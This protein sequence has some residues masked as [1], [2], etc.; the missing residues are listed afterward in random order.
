MNLLVHPARTLAQLLEAEVRLRRVAE[1]LRDADPQT[2][3]A[4]LEENAQNAAF[5]QARELHLTFVHLLLHLRPRPDLPGGP[6][7]PPDRRLILPDVTVALLIRAAHQQNFRWTAWVLRECFRPPVILDGK[8]LPL[9]P[10]VDKIPLGVRK[11][12]ARI[13]DPE[14]FT[15]LLVDTTPAVIQLLAQNPRL[16]ENHALVMATLRPTHPYALQALLMHARWLT[17]IKITE[18]VVRSEA[19][20]PWLV[21]AL[22]PLL[23][24]FQQ[25]AV[26][27][28]PRI[29]MDVREIL[30]AWSQMDDVLLQAAPRRSD[31]NPGIFDVTDDDLA[32]PE[33]L[34]ENSQ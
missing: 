26:V 20:P 8:L 23:P 18:A 31:P 34:Q 4:I 22:T 5:G 10:S 25:Q 3:T 17:N 19:A 6:L 21:L 7:P 13:P 12:R 2:A 14:Q 15:A 11:E 28:L 1:W 24:R 9:H 27:N 30:A 32:T 33:E 16:L 29:H